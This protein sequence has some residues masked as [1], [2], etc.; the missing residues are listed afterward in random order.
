MNWTISYQPLLPLGL[1]I[2]LAAIAITL[3][4]MALYVRQRGALLRGLSLACLFAALLNPGINQE[5]RQPLSDIAVL[6]IDQSTSQSIAKRSEQT[7]QAVKQLKNAVTGLNNLE[8]RTAIVTSGLSTGT[9]GTHAF[10]ALQTAL[11]DIPPERYA[12]TILITDGQVHDVPPPR[13]SDYSGPLH[14]LLTGSQKERDRRVLIE[15]AP[16]FAIVGE[17]LTI[18][19]K[20]EQWGGNKTGERAL[21]NIAIDGKQFRQLQVNIGQSVKLTLDV[22]HGGQNIIEISAN[23][24]DGE[25]SRQNNRAITIV[26]GVR[27]RLQVLL[28]SGKPH[29]GERTWRNLLKADPSVDLVHF[30]ILRPPQKQDGT[31]I[32]ELSL[33]AFPTRELFSKKLHEFDLVIFDRYARHGV[34]PGL[35]LYNIAEYVKNGGAVLVAAGPDYAGPTSIYHSPLADVLPAI[36]TGTVTLTPFRPQLTTEGSRHPIARNLKGGNITKPDWGKWFRLIDTERPN[37]SSAPG[38]AMTGTTLMTGP[39]E[40]PLLLIARAQKGRIAQLMSDHSWLWARGYDGGGPQAELLRRMAHW[41]MREPDLEEEKLTG[42]Q[43]AKQLVISRQTMA[44]QTSPVTITTPS[45]KTRKVKLQQQKPGLW[46]A[47]IEIA[48]AGIH[49]LQDGTKTT[50][51]GVG[52]PDPRETGQIHST[53][54]HLQKTVTATGGSIKRIENG[55]PRLAMLNPGRAL[56]GSGWIGLKANGVYDV[57]SITALPLFSTLLALAALLALICAM[58]Y[59][60]GR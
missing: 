60:E 9:D 36:P 35:Y 33:I 48:E 58:W 55:I 8:L 47:R 6:L 26:Q 54:R 10:K 3:T 50:F 25:L 45:G 13:Q 43:N 29:P 17:S 37:A 52:S 34:L 30:T 27:D 22:P 42:K 21:V 59:R 31:P 32:N 12:G 16:K 20:V 1:L 40:K 41:L 4:I 39:Q 14:V 18:K 19:F 51:A 2:I 7:T 53:A 49:K 46:Q 57:R 28:V 24:F 11:Q 44:E 56:A 15:S 5:N 38:A 23:A